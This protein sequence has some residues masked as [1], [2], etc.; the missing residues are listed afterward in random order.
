MSAAKG[1]LL[2]RPLRVLCAISVAALGSVYISACPVKAVPQKP[3]SAL[4]TQGTLL[5]IDKSVP[6]DPAIQQ[7]IAPYAKKVSAEMSEV[8]AQ[9]ETALTRTHPEGKMGDLVVDAMRRAASDSTGKAVDIAFTNAGGVRNDIG[10]GP[11]TMGSVFEVMPFD[12][13]IVV[14]ELTGEALQKTLDSVAGRG[15]DPVSGMRMAVERG[16]AVDVQ[17]AGKPLDPKAHYRVATND[18]VFDGGGHFGGLREASK[19]VRTGVLLR[20]ALIDEIRQRSQKD[21]ILRVQLDGRM[22]VKEAK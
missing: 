8:I 17:I 4:E 15:G 14:F 7:M 16:R 22:R 3:A 12:N 2:P 21:G 11:I 10:A 19:V 5:A 18:Y 6:A 13:T 20:D 1:G 9:A